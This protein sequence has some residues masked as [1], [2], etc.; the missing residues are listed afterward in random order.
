MATLPSQFSDIAQYYMLLPN[1]TC[2]RC[3]SH[4]P[5]YQLFACA[6]KNH[7]RD[8]NNNWRSAIFQAIQ[9]CGC[10]FPCLSATFK[11]KQCQSWCQTPLLLQLTCFVARRLTSQE[12][13]LHY[14]I[15]C[16]LLS[17]LSPSN[18]NS[19]DNLLLFLYHHVRATPVLSDQ[20][21]LWSDEVPTAIKKSFSSLRSN[22]QQAKSVR[23]FPAG[24]YVHIII[25]KN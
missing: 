23:S 5:S 7:S 1:T 12:G 20:V 10:L 22:I 6:G 11:I 21:V 17:C 2:Y 9:R 24:T 18:R 4:Q 8:E 16:S 13:C 19:F 15:W 25:T 14:G 3:A